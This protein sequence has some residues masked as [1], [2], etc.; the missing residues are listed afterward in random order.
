MNH[1]YLLYH[2]SDGELPVQIQFWDL[3]LSCKIQNCLPEMLICTSADSICVSWSDVK[4]YSVVS[5]SLW[6]HGYSDQVIF[7]ARILEWVAIPFSRESSQPRDRT[8]VSCIADAFFTSWATREAQEYWSGSLSLSRAS[9]WP[10]NGTGVSCTTGGFFI[11]WVISEVHAHS[12]LFTQIFLHWWDK[13]WNRTYHQKMVRSYIK[14]E[15]WP[16][17]CRNHPRKSTYYL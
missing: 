16:T 4:S 7:Q 6:P 14:I 5:T 10:R 3:S 8:Q 15:F 1:G 11:S 17:I 12:L 2:N 9:S 13:E